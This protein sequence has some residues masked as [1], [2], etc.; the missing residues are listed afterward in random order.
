MK[1][2][3]LHPTI[4][5]SIL[6]WFENRTTPA[7][8]LIGPPGVGKTT[9]AYRVMEANSMRLIQGPEPVLEKLFF[10]F[11]NVEVSLIW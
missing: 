6:Q 9:L 11:Y 10:L 4:E 1:T 2:I 3:C 8:F 7:V 5:N